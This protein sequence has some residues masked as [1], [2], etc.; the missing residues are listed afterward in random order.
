ML[1]VL[2]ILLI[3]VACA[4]GQCTTGKPGTTCQ[5]PLVVKP[6]PVTATQ[7]ALELTDI[8]KP[9]PTPFAT[10]YILSIENGQIVES[11]NGGPYHTLTG[12]PGPQGPPG[13]TATPVVIPLVT[14]NSRTPA[15]TTFWSFPGAKTELF[16]DIVRAQVDLTRASQARVYA[17]I[18]ADHYGSVGS[19]F[20][21]EFSTNGLTWTQL[22]NPV[23][24]SA[25]GSRVSKWTA[26]PASA[27]A[28]V[29]IRA[30][31][32]NGTGAPID[33]KAVQLQ[34]Q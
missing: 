29:V 3:S 32:V 14:R 7:E 17:E 19:A 15:S 12:T 21:V 34:V 5:G 4:F 8:V 30:V 22:T 24:V 10:S 6:S 16:S 31:G 18:G 20:Y 1:K 25:A 33:I 27:H 2:S 28:D 9:L 23:D 13:S 11:D 26:L